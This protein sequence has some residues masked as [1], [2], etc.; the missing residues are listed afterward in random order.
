M[1]GQPNVE[2]CRTHVIPNAAK[3]LPHVYVCTN[4]C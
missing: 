4:D 1:W 3:P 2:S